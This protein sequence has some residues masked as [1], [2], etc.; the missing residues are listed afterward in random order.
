M[1]L[2]GDCLVA[3]AFLSYEGAFSC[4]FRNEMMYE[5]WVKDLEERGVPMSKPF[6]VDNLLT[7]EVEICRS[8]G[9]KE[10]V[11]SPNTRWAADE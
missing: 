4:D 10:D 3:A 11:R 7:D 1:R 2:L 9:G 6:K 8:E 5:I